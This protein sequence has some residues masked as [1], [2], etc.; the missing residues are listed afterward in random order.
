MQNIIDTD[1][2]LDLG[3]VE[4]TDDKKSRKSKPVK[5]TDDDPD[6]DED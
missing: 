2:D 6:N 1:D 3:T 5:D 4:N